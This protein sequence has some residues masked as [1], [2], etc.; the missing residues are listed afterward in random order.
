MAYYRPPGPPADPALVRDLTQQQHDMRTRVRL[1]PLLQEPRLIAGCDSSFPTPDTILSVFVLLRFPS[2]DVVEKVY[3]TSTV[4][5]PYIPGLLSFREAPNVL[6]AYQKL[7]QQPDVIMVDGHG[8]AHPRRMGIAAHL[9]VLLDKP[10][11]GV[12]K[13]KLTGEY[14][15]P[16]PQ[17][18]STSPLLDR[19]GELLG[20]VIRS[21]D[22]VQPLFVSPGHRCDQATATRLTLACLRG[23]KLPEPTR[24][25][26]HWA[27]EFK[28]ELR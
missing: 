14:Q 25:A 11:F 7:Q 9:G 24:L 10:T 23:Y 4:T 6:L 26:D 2:L 3:H 16:G 21:K 12:A 28:K 1:E 5:L 17:R 19:S 18:G 27:E 20:E 8:I 13:Q 15:E 22:K